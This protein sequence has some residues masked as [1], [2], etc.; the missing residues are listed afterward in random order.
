[1]GRNGVGKSSLLWALQGSGP[2]HGGKV[3]TAGGAAECEGAQGRRARS[4]D[5]ERPALVA[6]GCAVVVATHDVEFVAT[7][8]DRVVVVAEGEIV[9]DGGMA[10]A[11]GVRHPGRQDPRRRMADRRRGRG[12][13]LVTRIRRWGPGRDRDARGYRIVVAYLFGF[14]MNLWFRP[15]RSPYC[16]GHISYVPATRWGEPAPLRRLHTPDLD[17]R[18]GRARPPTAPTRPSP[19]SRGAACR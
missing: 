18:V 6:E 11:S 13:G 4:A 17:G 12:G 2:R 15:F 9:A 5:R 19:R 8:A 10:K 14:L 1:M 16:D 7:V 3:R